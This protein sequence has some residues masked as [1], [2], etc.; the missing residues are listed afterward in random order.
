MGSLS[1]WK[2]TELLIQLVINLRISLRAVLIPEKI[3]VIA[4][5]LS[6][7]D[8]TLPTE[9]SLNQDIT[10]HLFSHGGSPQVDLFTTRWNTKL[11]TFLSPVPDPWVLVVDAFSLP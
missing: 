5:L 8:Q 4:N 3:N 7:Q 10:R 6:C 1:L 9:W 2:E 11:P